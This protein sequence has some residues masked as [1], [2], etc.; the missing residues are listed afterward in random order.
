MKLA[1]FKMV[2][3]IDGGSEV[4]EGVTPDRRR[5]V[6]QDRSI[7]AQDDPFQD[8]STIQQAHNS[9]T[10]QINTTVEPR[11]SDINFSTFF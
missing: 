1:L 3:L 7:M 8:L 11:Y 2:E 4:G 9:S 5:G 10:S 6:L